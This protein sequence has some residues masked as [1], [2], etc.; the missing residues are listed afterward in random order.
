M[1]WRTPTA[2]VEADPCLQAPWRWAQWEG[3]EGGATKHRRSRVADDCLTGIGQSTNGDEI[4]SQPDSSNHQIADNQEHQS[5]EGTLTMPEQN[6]F[7]RALTLSQFKKRAG[8]ELGQHADEVLRTN[9]DCGLG[10]YSENGMKMV[11]SYGNRQAD[12]P[13]MPP[14]GYGTG[15]L[16]A[17]CPPRTQPERL[18]RSPVMAALEDQ[19]RIPQIPSRFVPASESTTHTEHPQVLIETRTSSHPRPR[20]TRCRIC[21]PHRQK[22]RPPAGRRH[23]PPIAGTTDISDRRGEVAVARSDVREE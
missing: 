21:C 3:R 12:L 6:P 7:V 4:K 11:V 20:P 15:S 22:S 14:S 8:S 13:G 19:Q 10:L 18:M 2:R 1:P 17:Y 9:P 16:L 5:I 23:R